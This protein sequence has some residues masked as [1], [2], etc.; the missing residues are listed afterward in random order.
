MEGRNETSFTPYQC[1]HILLLPL[2]CEAFSVSFGDAT[3]PDSFEGLASTADGPALECS[4]G[5][6]G[7]AVEPAEEVP[8]GSFTTREHRVNGEVVALSET[9]LE[10]RNFEYDGTA[11]AA[12]FWISP[13]SPSNDGYLMLDGAPTSSCGTEELPDA[14]GTETYR[15]E[16][17][18]GMVLSDFPGG[19]IS[20]WYV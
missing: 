20:V 7:G 8:L 15:V 13:G 10:V 14:D 18:E 2:Q 19:S 1:L 5:D 12:F 9:V 6:D 16:M 4:E 3:L 11:P 17:P